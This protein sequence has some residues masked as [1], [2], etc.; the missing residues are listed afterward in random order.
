M[1]VMG[2]AEAYPLLRMTRPNMAVIVCT[3]LKE[4]PDTHILAQVG[5]DGF[6]MKPFRPNA[7]AEEVRRVLDTRKKS[8]V[9]P[10]GIVD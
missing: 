6:L 2:G 1:P 10:A 7:L 9:L 8:G 4:G 3:G 5:L